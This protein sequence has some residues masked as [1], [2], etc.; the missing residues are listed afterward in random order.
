MDDKQR[1]KNCIKDVVE[2][3]ENPY[4]KPPKQAYMP[5]AYDYAEYMRQ[6]ILKAIDKDK[7]I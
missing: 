4:K 2:G 6:A 7:I 3:V 1:I 5:M